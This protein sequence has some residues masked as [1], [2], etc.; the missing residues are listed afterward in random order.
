MASIVTTEETLPSQELTD[1]QDGILRRAFVG[2]YTFETG[3]YLPQIE[4]AYETWGQLNAQG[5]NAVLVKHALTGDAHVSRG[6]SQTPGWWEDFVGPGLTVDTDKYFVVAIN[7]IGGCNGSTGP[8]SLDEQGNAWGS[9]FPFVTIKDSVRLEARLA[10]LLGVH[11][12]HAV[13]GGS[14][15]GARALEWAVEF[16]DLV[17]NV[18]VMA[19]SAQAT[20]EQI[21]FAQVQ[22]EAIRL[23]PNFAQGDYYA[24]GVRPDA[25]L[26]LARRLAHITY[27]SEAELE[28]RF[29]RNAQTGEQPFATTHGRRGRYQVESY[30]DHQATKL[31]HRFDANSYLVLTEALMSHD[32]A[33]GYG[34]LSEALARLA[35]V[36]VVV[37]AVNSDRLYFPAQSEQL[38]ASLPK[39]K[40]VHFIDSPIGHDGF[41]T[42]AKQL[43]PVLTALV[44]DD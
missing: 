37:A 43:G 10:A 5:S 14:M 20:A 2:E 12:W 13:I 36:N 6:D 27:R 38:A 31:V 30:L 32:V 41:L 25:G 29:A 22:T 44:F 40:P 19:S 1:G 42:E 28:A 24:N 16:P 7:I 26:G 18:V 35:K 39:P 8:S 34:S 4:L 21:A 11:T 15:G 9:R 17:K 3:G 33:R 23:D